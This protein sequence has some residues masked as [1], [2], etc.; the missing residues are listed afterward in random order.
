MGSQSGR[1]RAGSSNTRNRAGSSNS[2]TMSLRANAGYEQAIEE[3]TRSLS[4]SLRRQRSSTGGSNLGSGTPRDLGS[5]SPAPPSRNKRANTV[6]VKTMEVETD[7]VTCHHSA[8]S[9]SEE[10][11]Q[12]TSNN[13]D[14]G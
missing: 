3:R 7:A 9:S 4:G 12:M 8:G 13:V 2:S 11:S 6:D 10:D 1:V 5:Q 14:T